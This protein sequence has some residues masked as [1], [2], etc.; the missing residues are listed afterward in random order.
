[1]SLQLKC[2]EFIGGPLDGYLEVIDARNIHC[3]EMLRLAINENSVLVIC[4]DLPGPKRP[5]TRVVYYERILN[6][7]EYRYNYL[8]A[9]YPS[10]PTKQSDWV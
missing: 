8:G 3:S 1:M 4:G 7:D 5:P 10:K 9:A 6:H 2:V